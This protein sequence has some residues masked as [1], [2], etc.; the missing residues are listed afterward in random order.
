[1]PNKL[2]PTIAWACLLIV[3][4]ATLSPV[5]LRP[6]LMEIEP[7]WIVFLEHVSAFAVIGF[8]FSVTY[9]RA[10]PICLLVLGSAVILEL[11]QLVVP[12]RDARVVDAVE[13]LIGGAGG[14][15]AAKLIDLFIRA[16]SEPNEPASGK[17][18]DIA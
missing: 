16:N 4:S 10:I 1:M 13:K 8:L 18:N 12:D 7:V 15:I 5:Y 2:L 6:R 17:E 11:L 14:I 9:S 3:V